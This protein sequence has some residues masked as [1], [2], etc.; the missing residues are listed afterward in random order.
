MKRTLS[1]LA[2]IFLFSSKAFAERRFMVRASSQSIMQNISMNVTEALY[3]SST[4]CEASSLQAVI[5]STT[6]GHL[7][8]IDVASA[9]V[10]SFF[11]AYDGNTS[12]TG[13]A[14]SKYVSST[15]TRDHLYNVYFASGLA[16]SNQGSPPACID[17]HYTER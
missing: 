9:G 11:N 5:I 13:R 17:I 1:L 7:F 8:N 6:P 3:Y 12:T 16:V 14:I 10:G 15:G 2:I 4:T